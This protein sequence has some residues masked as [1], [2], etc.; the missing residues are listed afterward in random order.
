MIVS[1]E[2]VLSFSKR[3]DALEDSCNDRGC[4]VYIVSLATKISF[5]IHLFRF[6]IFTYSFGIHHTHEIAQRYICL[7][8]IDQCKMKCGYLFYRKNSTP[9]QCHQNSK[10]KDPRL[11]YNAVDQKLFIHNAI[12]ATKDG[13]QAKLMTS[14]YHLRQH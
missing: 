10:S 3:W 5:L 11:P 6:L 12:Q 1:F 2:V 7:A 4:Y 13:R 14:S 8:F 9:Q